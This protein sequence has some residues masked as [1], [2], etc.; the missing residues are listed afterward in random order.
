ML[1]TTVFAVAAVVASVIAGALTNSTLE[2]LF[3]GDRLRYILWV[4]G[5]AFVVFAVRSAHAFLRLLNEQDPF[6]RRC[7]LPPRGSRWE[8][9]AMGGDFVV[10][11]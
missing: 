4:S 2:P 1:V 8:G 7:V 9:D 11:P 5:T 10:K 3:P 6:L